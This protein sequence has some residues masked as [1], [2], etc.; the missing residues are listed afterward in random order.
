L[1]RDPAATVQ[2]C[3]TPIVPDD[4]LKQK[5]RGRQQALRHILQIDRTGGQKTPPVRGSGKAPLT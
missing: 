3:A 4:K 5:S 1:E 2:D